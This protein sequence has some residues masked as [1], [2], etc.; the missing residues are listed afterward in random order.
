MKSA[1]ENLNQDRRE[2]LSGSGAM[3][4]VAAAA[5]AGIAA[6]LATAAQ[7]AASPA[8]PATL[9]YTI[10][11][12]FLRGGADALTMLCPYEDPIYTNPSVRPNTRILP[13]PAVPGPGPIFEGKEAIHLQDATTLADNTVLPK[14]GLAP[15]LE[16][17]KGLYDSSK[18]CFIHACGSEDDTRSHFA[19]QAYM[20]RGET[21]ATSPADGN[22]W[23]GRYL[24]E[25][26]NNPPG[27]GK[28]RGLAF[29]SIKTTTYN[30][31]NGVTPSVDPEAFGYPGAAGGPDVLADL[32]YVYGAQ[33]NPVEESLLNDKGAIQK[34]GMVNWN[35]QGVGAYPDSDL[36]NQ[37]HKAFKV[38]RDVDDVEVISID[39]DNIGGKRW[40]THNQQGVFYQVNPALNPDTMY[41]LMRDLSQALKAFQDD[42]DTLTD[43]D[44]IVLVCS[45]FG[46]TTQENDGK[47]TDHGRGGIAMLMGKAVNTGTV[48][49]RSWPGLDDGVSPAGQVDLDVGTDLREIQGE[50]IEKCFGVSASLVFP[51]NDFTPNDNQLITP[52]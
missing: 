17:L 21:S 47:G 20:E 38:I 33:A 7:P 12:L 9:P 29:G 13:P 49:A 42:A 32:E 43:R 52:L 1:D 8:P 41:S 3:K 27:D 2:L 35:I 25:T 18:L 31:G 16:E 4:A 28:L 44:V 51:A 50:L 26:K 46:R 39:F 23:I 34:L 14:L 48:Y 40:D 19:Q 15:A 10:I 11:Q 24:E 5:G 36:G 45:E 37:F 30:G 6:K 22:G